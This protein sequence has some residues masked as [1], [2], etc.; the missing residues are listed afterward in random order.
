[1]SRGLI[2]PQ[3]IALALLAALTAF[4]YAVNFVP[5]LQFASTDASIGDTTGALVLR[6]V[7]IILFPITA[8][9]AGLI[10]F[11]RTHHSLFRASVAVVVC[12]F[13]LELLATLGVTAGSVI[14]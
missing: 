7:P 10:V 12:A 9:A 5:I 8:G 4:L 6:T 2:R 1:M 11:Y 13:A 3:H 14:P